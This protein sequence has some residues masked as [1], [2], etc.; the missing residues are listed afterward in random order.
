MAYSSCSARIEDSATRAV[1]AAHRP[2][3]ESPH[4]T[5]SLNLSIY[6][7]FDSTTTLA[8]THSAP[9]RVEVDDPPYLALGDSR[10]DAGEIVFG[11][12]RILF[13]RRGLTA[14]FDRRKFA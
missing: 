6:L 9:L 4:F 1:R 14:N 11:K 12:L 7:S 5:I 8:N 13:F 3:R 10:R 2:T